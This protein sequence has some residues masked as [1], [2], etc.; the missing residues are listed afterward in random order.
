MKKETFCLNVEA[1]GRGIENAI[2]TVERWPDCGDH[3]PQ[4]PS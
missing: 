1:K 3:L 4:L 2:A